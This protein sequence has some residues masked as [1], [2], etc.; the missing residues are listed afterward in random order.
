MIARLCLWEEL[1]VK[2]LLELLNLI[3]LSL[4]ESKQ[5]YKYMLKTSINKLEDNI[6]TYASNPKFKLLDIVF[7][8]F[9]KQVDYAFEMTASD[10]YY[11]LSSVIERPT[12]KLVVEEVYEHRVNC[13]LDA[14]TLFDQGQTKLQAAIEEAKKYLNI[15][16]K[17]SR[18]IIERNHIMSG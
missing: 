13:F 3:G 18:N 11:A 5:L 1:G 16:T 12:K 4:D 9:A 14:Y 2:K 15:M 17:E 7:D 8:S 6:F 10:F